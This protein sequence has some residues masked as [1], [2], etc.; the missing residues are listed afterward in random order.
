MSRSKKKSLGFRVINTK[1]GVPYTGLMKQR[2]KARAAAITIEV[3]MGAKL[4]SNGLVDGTV[5]HAGVEH[6]FEYVAK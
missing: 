4:A 5:A 3:A 2:A 1:T 6:V